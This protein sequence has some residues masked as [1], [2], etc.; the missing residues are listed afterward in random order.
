MQRTCQLF[1]GGKLLNLEVP[2]GLLRGNAALM[3]ALPPFVLLPANFRTLEIAAM[4]K[5]LEPLVV[6][7]V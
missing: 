7:T 3:R 2:D 4:L 5:Q 6:K 1:G